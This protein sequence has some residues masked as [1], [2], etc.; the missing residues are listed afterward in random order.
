MKGLSIFITSFITSVV[1]KIIDYFI[2][3]GSFFIMDFVI[4]LVVKFKEKV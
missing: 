2:V 1:V 3:A 4:D